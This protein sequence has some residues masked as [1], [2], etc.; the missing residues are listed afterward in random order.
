M[1]TEH[2][3]M[4]DS[5]NGALSEQEE[6]PPQVLPVPEQADTQP[7][8]VIDWELQERQGEVLWNAVN[9]IRSHTRSS[10]TYTAELNE[11]M[12]RSYSKR[13]KN[14]IMALQHWISAWEF[15]MDDCNDLD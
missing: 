9:Q 3:N 6:N 8:E 4:A 12:R 2:K 15:N 11:E 14:V 7:D 5:S 10:R 13:F 1:N